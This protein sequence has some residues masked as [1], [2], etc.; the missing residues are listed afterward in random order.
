[1][2]EDT[3]VFDY[4]S[5]RGGSRSR[6]RTQPRRNQVE[7]FS[8]SGSFKARRLIVTLPLTLLQSSENKWSA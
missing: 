7:V 8:R 5:R 1:M 4:R 2:N 3:D 6:K